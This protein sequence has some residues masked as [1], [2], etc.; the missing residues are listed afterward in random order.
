MLKRLIFAL[1]AGTV[2]GSAH[3]AGSAQH[4]NLTT[5]EWPPY[6]HADGT[7]PSSEIVQTTFE[8][9]GY[10]VNS[11]V[12]PWNRALTLAD[13]SPK[14]IGVYPEYYAVREDAEAGGDRCIY[15]KPFGESPVGFLQ[16]KDNPIAFR[17]HSD[18]RS[19][20]IG[21][22]RGYQ[23][24]MQLD[25]MIADGD[26][27]VELSENDAQNIKM[28]AGRRVDAGVIDT[29]VYE[30][31]V[32]NDPGLAAISEDLEFHPRL[33]VT[34]TLHVCFENSPAGILARNAFD[35]ALPRSPSYISDSPN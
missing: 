24:E 35:A 33:L 3:A 27:R 11:Q 15:S 4:A 28:V 2:F 8:R 23:N 18:L 22:V 29:R 12:F 31:L 6:V 17:S 20:V 5:L 19:H 9:A 7:G 14:W 21:V 26:L 32:E 34:H 13:I 1:I 30:Y 10:Q 16:R 25:A